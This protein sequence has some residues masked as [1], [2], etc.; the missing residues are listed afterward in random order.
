MASFFFFV[1]KSMVSHSLTAIGL[2]GGGGV[3]VK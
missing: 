3:G 2:V 1:L